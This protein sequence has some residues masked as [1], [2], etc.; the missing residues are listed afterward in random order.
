MVPVVIGALRS[1]HPYMD[2]LVY[3]VGAL[4]A[5]EWSSMVPNKKPNLYAVCYV[6]GLGL[7]LVVFNLVVLLLTLAAITLFVYIKA[8]D[9]QH[10]KLL[11]LGVP[12][13]S[14]G[15]GALYWIYYQFDS[16]R[17]I[18][19][20]KGSFVMTLWFLLM[21]WSVDIGGY[22]VGSSLK[23]PKLAP[24]ISPNKTW[25]GLV[26]GVVLAMAVSFIY[27]AFVKSV[28]DLPMPLREQFWF[29]QLG[30]WVAVVAQIGDLAESAIK[31]HLG[32]KDSSHLIPGHG[33][34][35]DRIDGLIFAAPVFYC[36]F[37]LTLFQ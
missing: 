10:R 31:R 8:K 7:A 29:A 34:V 27:T 25:S 28:F 37:T 19:G 20:E 4:L 2:I 16:F 24:K 3:I 33:G 1:G 15:V 6:M 22:I 11:T 35:F 21:V 13:V 23:G 30:A 9:E 36:L 17:T 32:I 14:I 26:G 5:W 18:P 12:Y